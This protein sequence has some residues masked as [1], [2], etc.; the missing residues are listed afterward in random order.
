MAHLADIVAIIKKS[1]DNDETWNEV[2][3][4]MYVYHFLP[5]LKTQ[6]PLLM[7]KN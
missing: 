5:S 2:L 3:W 6:N 1:I 4:N 7:M